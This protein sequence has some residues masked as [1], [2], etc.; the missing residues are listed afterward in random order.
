MGGEPSSRRRTI[1]GCCLLK[2]SVHLVLYA[3][4]APKDL[5]PEREKSR[6]PTSCTTAVSIMLSSSSS[7]CLALQ[8]QGAQARSLQPLRA[9]HLHWAATRDRPARNDCSG[10][11]LT[12][13]H[14]SGGRSIGI[15]VR[16]EVQGTE[17]RGMLSIDCN[18][19]TG[20]AN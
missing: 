3:P 11:R 18:A 20:P 2:D 14:T 16:K 7:R 8:L 19:R 1:G 10:T 6:H 12:H 4:A 9:P 13:L 5:P 17:W 15:G